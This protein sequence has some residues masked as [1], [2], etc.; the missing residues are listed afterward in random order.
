VK[1]N[2]RP[3]PKDFESLG[4]AIQNETPLPNV[5]RGSSLFEDLAHA[6]GGLTL[7]NENTAM[8]VSA[9]YAC[10]NLLAG[11]IAA[12]PLNIYSQSPDGERDRLPNDAISY[13]LNEQFT[14][15]W[16][17]ANGWE[18]LTQ[19][20]LTHG[21]GFAK[22]KRLPNGVPIGIEPVHPLR[23]TVVPLADGSRLVYSIEP[24]WTIPRASTQQREILDQDDMLHIGGF[25]FD[26]CRG[27]SPLRYQLRMTGAV[28]MATQD[29]AARFFANSAR[30]DYALETPGALNPAQVEALREQIASSHQGHENAHK[31]MVLTGGMTMRTVTMPLEDIQ[32]LQTRQ[33]A[34]EEICRIYGVPPF[35]VGH[36]EKTTSWG[37][38]IEA[39]GTGFVR[40]A[41]RQ[42]LNKFETEINRK[43]FRTPTRVAQ[44]DVSELER[45]DTKAMAE[46]MRIAVGRAGEPGFMTINEVRKRLSLKR[47]E[48]GDEL[49]N[50]GPDAP[51]PTV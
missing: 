41:L 17:A 13:I 47:L 2:A 35:M 11:T 37:T 22:I 16:S 4:F 33:F 28:A 26:G 24:D 40:Y 51:Q 19:S 31:P 25:G 45:A 6:S 10:V 44:F 8:T 27:L 23:V 20:L 29:Y 30:P 7:P 5:I 48:G 18:F 21:D 46:S 15:R 3:A 1:L 36:N 43:L 12:L 49:N 32:L 34:I 38:G 39:M 14:P 50:G 9:I 42:H